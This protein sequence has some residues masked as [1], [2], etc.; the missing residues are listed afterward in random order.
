[1]PQAEF[2]AVLSLFSCLYSVVVLPLQ[3]VFTDL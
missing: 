1:L 3:P 2:I